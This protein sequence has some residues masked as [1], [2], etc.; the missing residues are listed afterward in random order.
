MFNIAFL[1]KWKWRLRTEKSG[2]W[3]DVLEFKYG[4]WR[5]LDSREVL[6]NESRWWRDIRKVCGEMYNGQL[7]V[8]NIHK[9]LISVIF[10]I[11]I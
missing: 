9:C 7:F 2:L 3:K 11:K 4:S 6:K 5:T 8:E 1:A 10:H